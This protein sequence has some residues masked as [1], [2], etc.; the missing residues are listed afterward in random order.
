MIGSL[1]GTVI[2]RQ[3]P[4]VVLLEVGGVGY[5]C[6]VTPRTLAEL[7]PTTS[8][9]LHCHHHVREDAQLLFGFDSRSERDTF[10]LL[11]GVHGVGP[12]LAMSILS[13]HTPAALSDIV[14]TN[15][16]SAMSTVPG[17]GKKTAERLVVELRNKLVATGGRGDVDGKPSTVADVREALGS[18]GYSGDEIR[19]ALAA[20]DASGEGAVDGA[21]DSATLLRDALMILGRT[22]A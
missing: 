7:E 13:V 21:V 6:H 4:N 15:D 9:F 10:E 17:V 2:E 16:L 18:L 14:A 8:A 22:R 12:S 3:P 11:I 19:E 1:R 20:V 5:L